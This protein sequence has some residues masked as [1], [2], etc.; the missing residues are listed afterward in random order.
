VSERGGG[1]IFDSGETRKILIF[2]QQNVNTTQMADFRAVSERNTR[3]DDLK[4]WKKKRSF[5]STLGKKEE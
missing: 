5:N 2:R 1:G 4:G 3:L